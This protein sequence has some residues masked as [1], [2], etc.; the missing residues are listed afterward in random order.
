MERDSKFEIFE[1]LKNSVQLLAALPD[2]Q[3]NALPDYVCKADELALDFDQWREMTIHNYGNDLTSVQRS[4]LVAL[5]DKLNQLTAQGKEYWTDQA[6]RTSL[7][8]QQVRELANH[9]LRAFSWPEETPRSY[10]SEY[11]SKGS[12]RKQFPDSN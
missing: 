5:D 6:V 12:L 11:I 9:V 10:A 1:R 8:W 3:L 2:E 7:E 4:S